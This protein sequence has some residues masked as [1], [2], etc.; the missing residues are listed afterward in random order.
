M[1]SFWARL[2]YSLKVRLP[3]VLGVALVSITITALVTEPVR[4]T[5]GYAPGQPINFSH[6]VHAGDMKVDCRYCHV[7]VE[8]GRFASVP[9]SQ[10]CMNCHSVAAVDRP[11][12]AAL[13]TLYSQGEPVVWKRVYRAPDFVYF[14]HDVH[15]AAKADCRNCHG[16]VATMDVVRQVQPMSMGSCLGCHRNASTRIVGARSDLVGPENCSSCHR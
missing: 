1:D 10:T 7:G 11:G 14:S 9:A 6:K 13:R 3:I 5:V 2:D 15:I 12:V 8:T 16:D 4:R